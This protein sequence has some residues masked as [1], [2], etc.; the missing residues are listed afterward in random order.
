M[1]NLSEL[2]QLVVP[3]DYATESCSGESN[4]GHLSA[5]NSSRKHSQMIA[6]NTSGSSIVLDVEQFQDLSEDK[7]GDP[8]PAIGVKGKVCD[9]KEPLGEAITCSRPVDVIYPVPDCSNVVQASSGGVS[10]ATVKPD[11]ITLYSDAPGQSDHT[12]QTCDVG[13]GVRQPRS[14]SGVSQFDMPCFARQGDSRWV[15]F[16]HQIDYFKADKRI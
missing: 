15:K 13:E 11:T 4:Q 3:G 7:T 10:N 1:V 16:A 8:S 14:G 5:S 6:A 9:F 2:P 12:P